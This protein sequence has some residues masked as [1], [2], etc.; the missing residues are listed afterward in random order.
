MDAKDVPPPYDGGFVN[1][2]HGQPSPLQ[3]PI[4]MAQPQPQYASST[5]TY[6]VVNSGTPGGCRVCH[7]RTWTGS[8]SCCAW[9]CCICCFPCG[10][11]CCLCMRQKKC[12]KCGFT[13]G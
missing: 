4:I 10:L 1:Q 11:I 8:Y 12:S 7:N 3:P 9:L 5:T 2:T 13:V 6:V